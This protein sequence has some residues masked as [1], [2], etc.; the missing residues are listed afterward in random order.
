MDLQRVRAARYPQNPFSLYQDNS[1]LIFWRNLSICEINC[2]LTDSYFKVESTNI[3]V[4]RIDANHYVVSTEIDPEKYPELLG[5]HLRAEGIL[6]EFLDRISITGYARVKLIKNVSTTLNIVKLGAQFEMLIPSVFYNRTQAKVTPEDI[7]RYDISEPT[8]GTRFAR[9]LIRKSLSSEFYEDRFLSSYIALER[10]A[11]DETS[12]NVFSQCPNCGSE[13]D[14]GRKATARFI[15]SLLESDGTKPKIAKKITA[16]RGQIAHGSREKNKDFVQDAC[17]Y[18]AATQA[19]AT[20]VV[21]DRSGAVV[22]NSEEILYVNPHIIYT[23]VSHKQNVFSILGF[24][25]SAIAVASRVTRSVEATGENHQV[26]IGITTD[27]SGFIPISET[28]WPALLL[29]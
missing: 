29:E 16:F 2:D 11:D 18:T 5:A 21:A 9:S 6:N 13:K 3:L 22:R 1:K 25:L 28:A 7:L 8:E 4:K 10:I 19:V 15:R 12:E 26:D 27:Q 24:K 23:C 17:R 20:G 14:T